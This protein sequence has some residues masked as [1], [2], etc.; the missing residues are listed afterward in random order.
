M[1]ESSQRQERAKKYAPLAEYLR[2]LPAKTTEI[3][4]TFSDVERIIN[5][6]LPDSAFDHRQ[7][8][9][10]QNSGSHAPLWMAAGF[11]TG[12]VHMDR[13]IVRFYRDTSLAPRPPRPLSLQDVVTEVNEL[14]EMR[15]IGGLQQWR[16]DRYG[17]ARLAASTLFYSTVEEDRDYAY[18]VGGQGEL[19]FNVGFEDVERVYTFRH[20]V[21]FSL[22]PTQERPDITP[23][24]PKIERF[25]EYL[26][27]YPNR[28]D[29][30]VMW[31][32]QDGRRSTNYA[33]S[34]VP[35]YLLRAP[36]FIFIGAQQRAEEINVNLILDDFDRLLPLYEYVEGTAS[37]PTLERERRGFEFVPGNKARA[38]RTAYERSAATVDKALRHNI[39][40]AALFDYLARIHGENNVSGEQNCGNRTLI[41]VCVQEDDGYV[42]YELKT[43]LSAQSCIRE[44]LGQLMEY[45]YW[46][47][48]QEAKRLVIV[49]E[50]PCDEEATEYIRRLREKFSF[51]LEYRQFDANA[52][53]LR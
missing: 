46:P 36:T 44:A 35:D 5:D 3:T 10:N 6:T 18:H 34:S 26:R 23:I 31:H 2:Q 53:C 8:W 43:G 19:Q 13:R 4:L 17:M 47:G 39:L 7:W 51:P 52:G 22:Q 45:S 16:K 38:A 41:D 12:P 14:A 40:Q 30:F 32:W 9:E 50:A 33:V 1:A 20:G 37:F 48:A 11:K 49:G 29:G 24:I 21:A 42:Y 15:P 27:I 28:F 25:N